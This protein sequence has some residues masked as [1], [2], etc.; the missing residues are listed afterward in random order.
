[1]LKALLMWLL[2]PVSY[3]GLESLPWA[4]AAGIA[5]AFANLYF[6]R[7]KK[8]ALWST[9]AAFLLTFWVDKL[10]A[11]SSM[12]AHTGFLLGNSCLALVAFVAIAV[13]AIVAANDFDDGYRRSRS[14]SYDRDDDSQNKK[15]SKSRPAWMNFGVAGSGVI[16]VVG[17]FATWLVTGLANWSN[18]PVRS[19]IAN[20]T[21]AS[22]TDNIPPTDPNH[23]VMVTKSMAAYA[24]QNAIGSAG[25]SLS[26]VY[27]TDPD[28]YTL[29]TVDGH[30]WWIAPL[31]YVSM[32]SQ[33]DIVGEHQYDSPGFIAVDAENPFGRVQVKTGYHIRYA[34]DAWYSENLNRYLYTHGYSNGNLVDATLEVDDNWQ[35]YWTVSVTQPKLTVAGDS[36]IQALVVNAQTGEIQ[37]Y[38]PGKTPKWVDRIISSDMV[39]DLVGDWATFSANS[40]WINMSGA[41]QMKI[42]GTPEL[43]YNSE[44]NSVWLVPIS[45]NNS[46]D[47][48]STGIVVYNTQDQKGTFYPGLRGLGIGSGINDD[49][50]NVGQNVLHYAVLSVQLY[51]IDGEPTWVAIYGQDKGNGIASF[52]AI[53]FMDARRPSPNAVIFSTSKDAGLA[54]YADWLANNGANSGQVAQSGS[55][56]KTVTAKVS[57][58]SWNVVGTTTTYY[59][60]LDGDNHLFTA[61]MTVNS[62]LPVM[63]EGD[64]VTV[65]FLDTHQQTEP[66]QTLKDGS[67]GR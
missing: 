66:L 25:A 42:G 51:Q 41:G 62:A 56:S 59:L 1:M 61:T 65:S 20:I 26:S 60:L 52:S 39:N 49:F 57:R 27:K 44:D 32:W 33:F 30:L 19:T 9:G 58:I 21:Q 2:N 50:A 14:Y 46:S 43:V 31:K 48:S 28:D 37:A 17:L 64:T 15:K 13:G 24:G 54:A 36:T 34:P 35:P 40:S 23:M 29:Q 4:A 7:S 67:I 10:I 38:A 22:A 11:F 8:R 16:L 45:S 55:P 53:G 6:Q 5:V 47:N 63:K 18:T 3:S 12:P